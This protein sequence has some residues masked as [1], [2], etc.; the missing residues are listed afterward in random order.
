MSLATIGCAAAQIA[1][2]P[3]QHLPPMP[4]QAPVYVKKTPSPKPVVVGSHPAQKQRCAIPLL[5]VTPDSKTHFT[6]QTIAPPKNPVG[7]MAYVT[8]PPT[9]GEA[10]LPR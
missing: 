9:C 1:S 10:G 4:S 6:A 5:N 2:G 7:A 8:T 3:F